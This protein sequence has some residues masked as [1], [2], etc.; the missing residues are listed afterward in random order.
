MTKKQDHATQKQNTLV[1]AVEDAAEKLHF[2]EHTVSD[3]MV[4]LSQDV[5]LVPKVYSFRQDDLLELPQGVQD[6]LK[7]DREDFLTEFGYYPDD[8]DD[9]TA[10]F[11]Y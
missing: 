2:M 4:L 3:A 9:L 5:P 1:D 11:G 6:F 7:A 8:S 10:E